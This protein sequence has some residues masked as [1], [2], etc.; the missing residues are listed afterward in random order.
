MDI[1]SK[2]SHVCH[3]LWQN[4]EETEYIKMNAIAVRLNIRKSN[5]EREGKTYNN[6]TQISTR[7]IIIFF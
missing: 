2:E 4:R 3:S 7:E 1:L 6:T 5:E